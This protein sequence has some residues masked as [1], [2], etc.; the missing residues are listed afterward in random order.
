MFVRFARGT[1]QISSVSSAAHACGVSPRC[2]LVLLPARQAP[3]SEDR[4]SAHYNVPLLRT[5][6]TLHAES[7]RKFT[8]PRP[9][10]LP[11]PSLALHAS[12]VRKSILDAT[13]RALSTSRPLE[14]SSQKGN[15]NSSPP[16][17]EIFSTN[18]VSTTS[19][20]ASTPPTKVGRLQ[21]L[22]KT[23]GKIAIGTYFG[24]Y[25]VTISGMFMM[26]KNG[27]LSVESL[28]DAAGYLEASGCW[29][30][31]LERV[32]SQASSLMLAWLAAKALQPVRIVATCAA[33]PPLA[34]AASHYGLYTNTILTKPY[35]DD[36]VPPTK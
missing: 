16:S 29:G 19:S 31:G 6:K 8:Q 30:M 22:V 7:E 13:Y 1:R 10:T 11:L 23:Y 33:T 2:A 18:S 26:I 9:H 15:S 32:D 20:S 5:F 36:E 4:R 21:L 35:V 28:N 12:G 27:A 25:L 17:P 14:C 34:K 24:I 3:A